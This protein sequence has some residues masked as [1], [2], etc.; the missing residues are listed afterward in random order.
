MNCINVRPEGATSIYYSNIVRFVKTRKKVWNNNVSQTEEATLTK[1][2]PKY[3]GRKPTTKA[4]LRNAGLIAER[5]YKTR[6][7]H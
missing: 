4:R 1:T 6:S 5:H 7:N 3:I 2:M